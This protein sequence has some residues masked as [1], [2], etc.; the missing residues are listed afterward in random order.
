MQ[1]ATLREAVSCPNTS[2]FEMR[3]PSYACVSWESARHTRDAFCVYLIRFK[4]WE[5]LDESDAIRT[6][7]KRC[8]SVAVGLEH[9]W[10][11]NR[12]TH[13]IAQFI[14]WSVRI[15]NMLPSNIRARGSDAHTMR[16]H[17]LHDLLYV[18]WVTNSH[19]PFTTVRIVPARLNIT[20][21]IHIEMPIPEITQD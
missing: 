20:A 18:E 17:N 1:Q 5:T 10:A 16:V 11:D 7:S 13:D 9:I 12:E 2:A 8:S 15:V 4:S 19:A 21:C 3:A 6:H 14:F